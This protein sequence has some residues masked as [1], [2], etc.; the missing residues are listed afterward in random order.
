MRLSSAGSGILP[1]ISSVI[2]GPGVTV[3]SRAQLPSPA[4]VAGR[5]RFS[6]RSSGRVS[7]KSDRCCAAFRYLRA[8]PQLRRTQ[9]MIRLS[10]CFGRGM[11]ISREENEILETPWTSPS[12]SRAWASGST[13][14]PSE[15]GVM[16]LAILRTGR[17]LRHRLSI[18]WLARSSPLVLLRARRP[19][20]RVVVRC[21]TPATA[22]TSCARFAQRKAAIRSQGRGCLLDHI[23]GA[24]EDRLRDRQT[25]R[26]RGLQVD[27]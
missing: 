22:R 20:A 19:P 8:A 4:I 25:E 5:T 16:E 15:V 18:S 3:S 2:H 10:P 13:R 21:P 11:R 26:L 9:P 14:P 27:H 17:P 7:R 23:V 24:G 1:V 12:G 6:A